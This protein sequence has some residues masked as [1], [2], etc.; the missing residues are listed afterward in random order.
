MY[1]S[2]SSCCSPQKP[3]QVALSCAGA[4]NEKEIVTDRQTVQQTNTATYSVACPWLKTNGAGIGAKEEKRERG[5]SGCRGKKRRA[6]CSSSTKNHVEA[7]NRF[8]QA[9]AVVYSSRNNWLTKTL[10]GTVFFSCL[11]REF[12]LDPCTWQ[13]WQETRDWQTLSHMSQWYKPV[14]RIYVVEMCGTELLDD[15]KDDL[16]LRIYHQ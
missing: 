11:S 1:T 15:L 13:S 7:Q 3:I 2:P 9:K 10:N 5:R 14:A 8:C 16:S 6:L 4:S 12:K